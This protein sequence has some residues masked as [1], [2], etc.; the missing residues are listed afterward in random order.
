MKTFTALGWNWEITS[1]AMK[2]VFGREFVWAKRLHRRDR[3]GNI[4]MASAHWKPTVW[5]IE[6]LP[7]EVRP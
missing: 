1:E 6:Q 3:K 4:V 7:I 2:D 5:H